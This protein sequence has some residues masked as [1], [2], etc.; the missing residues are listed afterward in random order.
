MLKND[1][2]REHEALVKASIT[3]AADYEKKVSKLADTIADNADALKDSNK[4]SKQYEKALDKITDA[5]K[6]AFGDNIT[7]EFV[8]E[9]LELFKKFAEG[10]EGS[11]DDIREAIL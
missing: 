9:N 3:D 11:A 4:E 8:E 6:E 1:E 10:S 2:W 5:A 7:K